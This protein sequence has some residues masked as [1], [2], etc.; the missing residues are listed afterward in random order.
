[1]KLRALFLTSLVTLTTAAFGQIRQEVNLLPP[2][3]ESPSTAKISFQ[4]GYV[5][6][7]GRPDPEKPEKITDLLFG[8]SFQRPPNTNG[9]WDLWRF[10]RLQ[11]K[12][13]GAPAAYDPMERQ[14]LK[15]AQILEEAGQLVFEYR[16]ALAEEAGEL[17]VTFA[18]TPALEE[19]MMVKA[20]LQGE[21]VAIISATL[22]AYPGNTTGPKERERWIAIGTEEFALSLTPREIGNVEAG[23]TLFNRMAQT[24]TGCLLVTSGEPVEKATATGNY[25]T[26]VVY[27]LRPETT[28]FRIA[29]GGYIEQ[30]TEEVVR[31]FAQEGARH[32][33]QALEQTKWPPAPNVGAHEQTFRELG[34]LLADVG[35]PAERTTAESLQA[36]YRDALASGSTPALREA[37]Q[38]AQTL[39]RELLTRA[40]KRWK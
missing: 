1:M 34:K 23:I 32:T 35:T 7:R 33:L 12:H 14:P 29:L 26:Q 8:L 27:H 21:G 2:E 17:I 39:T 4:N 36:R 15:S 25:G 38:E 3:S 30:S 22:A 31:M 19:W 9:G 20:S 10:L 40:L 16:W 37:L 18:Q 28:E 6:Y 11:V 13:E 5:D 24:E